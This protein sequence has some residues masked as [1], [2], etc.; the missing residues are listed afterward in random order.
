MLRSVGANG[1][2][3]AYKF[4]TDIRISKHSSVFPADTINCVPTISVLAGESVG[5]EFILTEKLYPY[6]KVNVHQTR[7]YVA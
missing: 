2:D 1:F 5:S 6:L 4:S 7:V 3:A